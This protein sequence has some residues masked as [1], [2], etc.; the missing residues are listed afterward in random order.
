VDVATLPPE[1]LVELDNGVVLTAEIIVALQLLD[2]PTQLLSAIFTNPAEAFKALSNV[3]A[4]MSPEVRKK[5]KKTILASVI[6]GGIATQSATTA[7]GIAAYRRK[8]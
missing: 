1:T 8:N 7:A 3:G 6:A 2:D 5:A 4:D